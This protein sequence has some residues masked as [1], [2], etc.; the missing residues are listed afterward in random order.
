[1]EADHRKPATRFQNTLGGFKPCGQFIEFAVDM[2]AQ[3]LEGPRCRILGRAHPVTQGLAHH[4]GKLGGGIDRPRRD[5]RAGDATRFRLF[6][7]KVDDIGNF[8]L[9]RRIDE[10]CRTFARLAHPHIERAVFLERK[11]AIGLVDLHRRYAD[12]EHHGIDLLHAA[13]GEPF[14]H[15]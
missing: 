7:I 1:M 11:A 3:R 8:G 15:F 10:I 12:I 2:D 4:I 5:N 9:V 14:I 6:A 13:F